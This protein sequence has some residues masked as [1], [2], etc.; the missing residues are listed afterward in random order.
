MKIQSLE[1]GMAVADAI[2]V[3]DLD[4]VARRGFQAVICNRRPGEAEDHPDDR[5]LRERAEALG[6]A[7]RCIP[8][9]PGEYGEADIAAFGRALDELPA[10]ILAFCRT[11]RRA[12]HLWAQSRAREPGCDIP[13]LLEA[14]HAAGHDPQPIREMLE[15]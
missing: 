6:L 1:P 11:G 8:V 2:G 3:A 9:T 12:V 4:E 13:A 5:A 10:P 7:W 14:A 15:A